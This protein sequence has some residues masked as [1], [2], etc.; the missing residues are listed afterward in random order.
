MSLLQV[1]SR[2]YQD[3]QT[4]V[5]NLGLNWKH[6]MKPTMGCFLHHS[7]VIRNS[8]TASHCAR[9]L[10]MALFFSGLGITVL[11][12]SCGKQESKPSSS[13]PAGTKVQFGAAQND[14]EGYDGL[15]WGSAPPNHN[16]HQL[17]SAGD[18][19]PVLN[20]VFG[21][22]GTAEQIGRYRGDPRG[23][24]VFEAYEVGAPKFDY[25]FDHSKGTSYLY[26]R[27]QLALVI[28]TLHDYDRAESELNRK[29]PAGREITADS[30]GDASNEAVAL[31]GSRVQGIFVGKV[32]R[33]GATNTR[34]YL[35]QQ[36]INGFKRDVFLVYIPDTYFSAIRD[37]WW[38][39][40]QHTEQQGAKAREMHLEQMQQADQR[41]IQ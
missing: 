29:Y 4:S 30:W 18:L 41:K 33:R 10:R 38:E 32:Y 13:I 15:A 37:E 17:D 22:P 35:L 20:K 27:S 14:P 3:N 24:L 11:A 40:F 8:D 16:V 26:Y 12:N 28:T 25:V 34:I 5:R 36:I 9:L 19:Q 39:N 2:S 21:A 31:A 7:L 1:W 6:F 23:D